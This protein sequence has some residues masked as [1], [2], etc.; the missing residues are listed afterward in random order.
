VQIQNQ[1]IQKKLK[2]LAI[3]AI[4]VHVGILL[5][6]PNAIRRKLCIIN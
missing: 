3:Y 2:K 5:I 4:V 1:K 6:I